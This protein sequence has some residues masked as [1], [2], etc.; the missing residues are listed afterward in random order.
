ME[1][2]SFAVLVSM[3]DKL[4]PNHQQRV[5]AQFRRPSTRTSY[6]IGVDAH[7]PHLAANKLAASLKLSKE[8]L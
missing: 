6:S 7:Y 4:N 3:A 8:Q 2:D 5:Q 1:A